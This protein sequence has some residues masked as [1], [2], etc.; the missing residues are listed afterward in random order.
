MPFIRLDVGVRAVRK[1]EMP[2]S[3]IFEVG[4]KR[5]D[6]QETTRRIEGFMCLSDVRVRAPSHQSTDCLIHTIP[7][8]PSNPIRSNPL[9]SSG[10]ALSPPRLPGNGDSGSYPDDQSPKISFLGCL[11][12]WSLLFIPN[13]PPPYLSVSIP[14]C[15]F[16]FP[17]ILT[18]NPNGRANLAILGK[19]SVNF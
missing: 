13:P 19:S 12:F 4:Q 6:E 5:R 15:F 17:L 7:S 10:R 9:Q 14:F 16:F 8:Y 2:E 3:Q 18:H 11:L 1:T